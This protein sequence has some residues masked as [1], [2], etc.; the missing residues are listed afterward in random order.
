MDWKKIIYEL[1][2]AG[3]TQ[4]VMAERCKCSQSTISEISRGEIKNPA[5]STG[6]ALLALHAETVS[7]VDCEK[8]SISSADKEAA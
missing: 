4:T 2:V 3:V 8:Q 7:T 6:A 1:S 5:Y